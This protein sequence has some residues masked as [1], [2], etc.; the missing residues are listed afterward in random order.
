M[1]QLQIP[2][3][4]RKAALLALARQSGLSIGF[5]ASLQCAGRASAI[6]LM[7]A[8]QAL[9]RILRDSGCRA[10]RL[11]SRTIAIEA[12]QAP[13]PA[14][15]LPP[16]EPPAPPSAALAEL[17]VTA[18]KRE[19]DLRSVPYALTA[20]TADDLERDGVRGSGDLPAVAAGVTVTNLGPGRDKLL[21]RGLSDGPLTGHTQSTVGIYLDE[22]RLTYNAPDPDLKWVDVA[23]V[24]VLRG[25]QG[26]LYGS[27]S[28]GGVL[29]VVTRAPDPLM[30]DGRVAGFAET[31]RDG[32]VSYGGEGMVNQPLAEGRGAVRLVGWWESVGG[33]VDNRGA[34]RTDADRTRRHGLRASALWEAQPDLTLTASVVQQSI[35][36]ADTHYA[37]PGLGT[38]ARSTPNP[39]PHD[40]DFLAADLTLRWAARLAD[41]TVTTGVLEHDVASRYDASLAPAA[42]APGGDAPAIYDDDNDIK[43]LVNE[44]RV[45]SRGQGPLQWLA[46][47]FAA[48]GQQDLS[49]TL[50]GAKGGIGY[51]ETRRDR[52]L[53]TALFG[54][55]SYALGRR[56]TLTAGGRLFSSSVRTRSHVRLGT[57]SRDFDGKTSDSGFAPKL[58]AAYAAAPSLGL[59][60]QAAE[61][62]RSG[63][64]NTSGPIGQA[65]G[66]GAGAAQPLRRYVGDELWSYE[67]GLRWQPSPN[68][69]MRAAVFHASWRDIQADLLLPSGL[70]FTGNI[71]DGRSSGAE[72]ETAYARGQWTFS[73]NLTAQ[74]PELN[75][76]DPGFA[77]RGDAGLPGVPKLA[78][79]VAGAYRRPLAGRGY[80]E[81]TARYAYVGRS[82]LTIDAQTAPAMGGY[83]DL[84]LG[85]AL[86]AGDLRVE[87]YGE[88]VADSRDDT[89][90]YGNPFSLR[91]VP[92][93]T[94]QRPRT[95]GLSVSRSF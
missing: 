36:S 25:P 30:R 17:V 88:N 82:H 63:G 65:F 61:G 79:G 43:G 57:A 35:N 67:A 15:R 34:G 94:P 74:E 53:E 56:L 31:T 76:P 72:L 4:P 89:F 59:Y 84:R 26:S 10:V 2:L 22:L 87:L 50:F 48:F 58:V 14:P 91:K 64:F 45:T 70:P 40:N 60:V 21:L 85:L 42:L 78:F 77:P 44:A 49:G 73:A 13:R 51:D 5:P 47:A 33:Y 23:R 66:A 93:T 68:W 12:E 16:A 8:T 6:G 92:Q 3:Q 95:I 20:L 7:T 46:G 28:I 39:E 83:G 55:A 90:A 37:Q 41:V 62:Y 81:A 19:V 71:G 9:E 38:F 11:D 69:R 75:R 18:T 80:L 1:L 32:G 29:H 27:G 52:L 24:E 86:A 54:E